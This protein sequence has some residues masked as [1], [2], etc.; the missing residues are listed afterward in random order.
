M[1][2]KMR[3]TGPATRRRAAE[4]SGQSTQRLKRGKAA[5][6]SNLS[7]SIQRRKRAAAAAKS[8]R[9]RRV[10]RQSRAQKPPAH[11]RFA[12]GWGWDSGTKKFYMPWSDKVRAFKRNVYKKV[13]GLETAAS[14]ADIGLDALTTVVSPVAGTFA[15]TQKY[16]VNSKHSSP[17][18]S[19]KRRRSRERSRSRKRR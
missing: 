11:N 17:S 19:R 9:R 3:A 16:L 1:I 13:P 10:T 5:P 8:Q 6:K 14:I 12:G 15:L 2:A 18:G 7:A 4:I